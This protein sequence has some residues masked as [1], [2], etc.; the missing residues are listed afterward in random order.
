MLQFL[1]ML[2]SVYSATD[3]FYYIMAEEVVWNYAPSYPTNPLT[4]EAFSDGEDIFVDN[5]DEGGYI[6]R[7][8]LKA[9]YFEYT[10]DTFTTRKTRPSSEE[11]LG[12]LGPVIRAEVGDTVYITFK[13]NGSNAYS[14]HPH[15][16]IYEKN[17]EGTSY[18]DGTSG[19]D[20]DDIVQPGDTHTYTWLARETSGPIPGSGMSTTNW[21]YHSHNDPVAEM[22]A[23][24]IGPIVI[25]A[26]G[27]CDEYL[28]PTDVD[29]EVF[30][31][32]MVMD[33]GASILFD[34]NVDLYLAGV[35]PGSEETDDFEESNLMHAMNGYLYGNLGTDPTIEV[36]AGELVRWYLM[37]VGNEVDLHTAHWHGNTVVT[38][39]GLRSDVERLLA[40]SY[41][42][43]DMIPEIEGK[44]LYHCHV[45]DHMSAGM[46]AYYTVLG[47]G[48]NCHSGSSTRSFPRLRAAGFESADDTKWWVHIIIADCIAVS[49]CVGLLVSCICNKRHEMYREKDMKVAQMTAIGV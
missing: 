35:E 34:D 31:L 9:L 4:G 36:T 15:G 1:M 46:M 22:N 7:E 41:T 2:G 32:F 19:A 8:Y 38:A 45:A 18:Q 33:E 6:G 24:L 10:D 43:A 40:G 48:S 44:W 23:G 11:H 49:A 12:F 13:N 28:K 5:V 16:F 14:M 30:S 20:H 26:E 37:A 42:T 27:M 47:C 39:D 21:F 17:S 29:Q 3:R 25:C